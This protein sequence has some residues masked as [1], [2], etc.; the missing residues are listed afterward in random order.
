[1][2][3]EL[4]RNPYVWLKRV[5][6]DVSAKMKKKSMVEILSLGT[7]ICCVPVPSK[8]FNYKHTH[9]SILRM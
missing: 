5:T 9:L 4:P 1:M 8:E 6:I 7:L 2:P 3:L